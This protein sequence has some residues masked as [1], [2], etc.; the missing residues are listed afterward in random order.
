M[1][2]VP[3]ELILF[4]SKLYILIVKRQELGN[5]ENFVGMDY[6]MSYLYQN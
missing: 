4:F 2:R 1:N 6:I 5:S 3:C